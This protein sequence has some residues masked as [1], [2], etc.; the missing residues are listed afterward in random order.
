MPKTNFGAL[1][2]NELTVWSRDLWRQAR[3]LAV[4]SRYIGSDDNALFQR[5]TELT[6]SKTGTKA[7][8]TLV[9]DSIDGGV[10]DDRQ[11]EGNETALV[12]YEQEIH[13]SMLRKA[14]RDYGRFADMKSV[15]NFRK[16]AQSV[17]RYWLANTL[18]QLVFLTLSGVDYSNFNQGGKR[19]DKDQWKD[20]AFASDIAPPTSRRVYRWAKNA[21]NSDGA[22]VQGGASSDVT[23]TDTVTWNLLV[24]GKAQARI[25]HIRPVRGSGGS[26][27]YHVFLSPQAMTS[28]KLDP[29]Y[30][31]IVKDAAQS[32]KSNPLFTGE[33]VLVDGL[34]IHDN[35]YVV[36]TANA[37][38]GA[39]YGA[40]GTVDGCQVLLCGAQAL[41]IA[42]IGAPT[43]EEE[44]FDYKNQV[45]IAS[46]RIFGL[47]KPQFVSQYSGNTLQDHGVMSIYV[48]Q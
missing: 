31:N 32:G 27:V 17:L 12:S 44:K 3:N 41:G 28:L 1:T 46:G 24:K 21:A 10:V 23:A 19:P 35:E 4:A 38:S 22:L 7:V 9:P 30:M 37:P 40:S 15:V 14:H 13:L 29:N 39:K 16:T 42:E 45:G 6:K 34:H 36:N 47:K 20:L 2:E 43:W 18:D 25:E 11:L 48:A 8:I 5:V 26:E 33:G